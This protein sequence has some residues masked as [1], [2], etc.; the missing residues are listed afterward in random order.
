MLHHICN[1]HQWVGG[2]CNHE[3]DFEHDENLTWFDRRDEDFIEL[4]RIILN[5]AIDWNY[6]IGLPQMATKSGEAIFTR[7][8]NPRTCQW[9]VKIVKCPKG[10]EYIPVLTTRVLRRSMD[11]TG[12]TQAV[13]LDKSDPATISPTIA[14][15]P[16]LPTK[17]IAA[18]KSRFLQDL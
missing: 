2:Q 14:H 4:Q 16:P 1:D 13:D 5:P 8:Y 18:R 17:E 12:V 10:Y 3:E 7:K 6:H 15:V 9:D 11:S